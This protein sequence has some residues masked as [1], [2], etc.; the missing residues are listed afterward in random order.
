VYN[1]ALEYVKKRNYNSNFYNLRDILA[2]N[3]TRKYDLLIESYTNE[4]ENC[5]DVER[6][7]LLRDAIITLTDHVDDPVKPLVRNQLI[8]DFELSVSNE[9]RSNAIKNV[10]SAY[11]SG[12]SNLKAGNIKYFNMKFS[13]K[14]SLNKCAELASSDISMVDGRIQICPNKLGND[15]MFKISNA[16]MA[17]YGNLKIE[18]NCDLIKIRN[19][20]FVYVTISYDREPLKIPEVVCGIDPGLRTFMT[21]YSNDGIYE[22][23]HDDT[24]R[25]SLNSKIDL[26]K[27]LKKHTRKK[28]ITKLE[29]KRSNIV[30][31]LHWLVIND[32]VKRND[33]ILYGDIKS[34]DTV[35][36]GKNKFNNRM[37]NDLK[38]YK[39]K[40]RF[41]YKALRNGKKIVPVNEMYTTKGCSKCGTLNQDV[42]TSKIYNCINSSCKYISGRDINSAKNILM[43]GLV[44]MVK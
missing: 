43:K 13:K 5:T 40:M 18:H 20:Y 32:I 33:L 34:H 39:F 19:E 6:K 42:G 30:D 16:N 29:Q 28:A 17:K 31:E 15:A 36:H 9:I 7:K 21:M 8:S 25:Q 4:L 35:K 1:K 41:M 12:F 11:T 26:L 23:N 14:T 2:T 27:T 22:Y 38:F 44:S 37:F 10:C 3:T 24:K